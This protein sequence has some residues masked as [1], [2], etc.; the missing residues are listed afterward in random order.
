[1]VLTSAS[2]LICGCLDAQMITPIPLYGSPHPIIRFPMTKYL[3]HDPEV[4]PPCKFQSDVRWEINGPTNLRI[5]P[6]FEQ[7]LESAGLSL[8]LPEDDGFAS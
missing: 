7:D 6:W 1:M 4:Y 8:D 3:F 2:H 5:R